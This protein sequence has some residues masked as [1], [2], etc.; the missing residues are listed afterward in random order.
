M[1]LVRNGILFIFLGLFAGELKAS[2]NATSVDGQQIY[3][4]F[5]D[6]LSAPGL[7]PLTLERGFRANPN[8]AASRFCHMLK[9]HETKLANASRQCNSAR[10]SLGARSSAALN[11]LRGGN[12]PQQGS[13]SL[14]GLYPASNQTNGNHVISLETPMVFN[15]GLLDQP[16]SPQGIMNRMGQLMMQ[17]APGY[18]YRVQDQN[19]RN[20][21]TAEIRGGMEPGQIYRIQRCRNNKCISYAHKIVRVETEFGTPSYAMITTMNNSLTGGSNETM[22]EMTSL[23]WVRDLRC[24][25]GDGHATIGMSQQD[26]YGSDE[27]QLGTAF[28]WGAEGRIISALNDSFKPVYETVL[29]EFK[30]NEINSAGADRYQAGQRGFPLRLDR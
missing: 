15:S 10:D 22:D 24:W 21:T 4:E 14:Y 9:Q 6:M 19:G 8:R 3:Q 20:L 2:C 11:A 1:K 23:T 12:N 29:N 5:V 26:I 7:K 25:T 16:I 18:T 28:S 13:V 27:G 30:Q 17:T